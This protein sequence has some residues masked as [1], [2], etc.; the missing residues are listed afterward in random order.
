MVLSA[1]SV[2]VTWISCNV[3]CLFYATFKPTF[4]SLQDLYVFNVNRILVFL[5]V[6]Y[7]G[8]ALRLMLFYSES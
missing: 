4:L 5:S 8:I 2:Q 6:F 7:Y 3:D 1:V